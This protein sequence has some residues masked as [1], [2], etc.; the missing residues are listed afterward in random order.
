MATPN[1]V[2]AAIG[3]LRARTGWTWAE[4]A[5]HVGTTETYARKLAEGAGKFGRAGAGA[6][7]RENVAK[8]QHTGRSQKPVQR[9]TKAGTPQK[10]RQ[11]A[12]A[13]SA[14]APV[15]K[16]PARRAFTV[17]RSEFAGPQGRRG[18]QVKVTLPKTNPG[19]ENGRHAIMDAMRRG[20]QGG[21]RLEFRV[22]HNG[23]RFTVIGG[24]GGYN[25]SAALAGANREGRDPLEWLAGQTAGNGAGGSSG[26]FEASEVESVEVIALAS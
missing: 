14:P 5:Q 6:S 7:L 19:R 23:G 13:P 17:T 21:R 12:G 10:V 9:I 24:K 4:V 15:R 18:W 1:E 20:A 22:T 26:D 16:P 11:K 8:V 3:E 2:G 25:A